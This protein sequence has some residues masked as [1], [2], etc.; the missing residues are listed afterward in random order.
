MGLQNLASSNH[1]D[2]H[3]MM[4]DPQTTIGL[5]LYWNRTPDKVRVQMINL[6]LGRPELSPR[7][8]AVRLTGERGEWLTE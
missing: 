7:E 1:S 4:G 2:R 6:A 8:L 3:Q 5:H